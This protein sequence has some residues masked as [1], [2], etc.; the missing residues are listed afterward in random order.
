MNHNAET[1]GDPKEETRAIASRWARE[2]P[3][4]EYE[5]NMCGEYE[6]SPQS[7]HPPAD[8][9]GTPFRVHCDRPTRLYVF[10]SAGADLEFD[11]AD[12]LLIKRMSSPVGTYTG[13]R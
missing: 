12:D 1:L 8:A 4:F 13:K 3:T 9:W 2:L 7:L 5:D 10:I 6:T 11:T